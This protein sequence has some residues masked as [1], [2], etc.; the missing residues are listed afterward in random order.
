MPINEFDKI[1]LSKSLGFSI[2][3]NFGQILKEGR[4]GHDYLELYNEVMKSSQESG[5]LEDSREDD[6]DIAS[7]LT[8]LK[9]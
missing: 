4:F 8:R 6:T 3:N 7:D 1:P 9:R 2:R 5:G